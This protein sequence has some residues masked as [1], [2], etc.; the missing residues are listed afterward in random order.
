MPGITAAGI[1]YPLPSE[2]IADGANAIKAIA[3]ILPGKMLAGSLQITIATAGTNTSGTPV[4][5]P[6]GYFTATPKVYIVPVNGPNSGATDYVFIWSSGGSVNGF[7]PNAKRSQSGTI[8]V[9]W[10]AI[11]P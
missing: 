9:N 2:P 8:T 5:Y 6:A 4:T 11:G 7:T 3:D 1:P 10:L